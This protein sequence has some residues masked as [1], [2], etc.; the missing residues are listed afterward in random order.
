MKKVIKRAFHL[1]TS[2]T[3]SVKMILGDGL[4]MLLLAT[5]LLIMMG[6]S[7]N[8]IPYVFLIGCGVWVS[9][10]VI[11]AMWAAIDEIKHGVE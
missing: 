11:A 3:L 6:G 4:I 1:L 7:K 10:W 5:F 9:M 8:I 2:D